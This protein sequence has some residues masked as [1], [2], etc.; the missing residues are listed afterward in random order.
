MATMVARDCMQ[1]GATQNTYPAIT[2]WFAPNTNVNDNYIVTQCKNSYTNFQVNANSRSMARYYYNS[3]GISDANDPANVLGVLVPSGLVVGEYRE[4]DNS[5][6][7]DTYSSAGRTYS[8]RMPWLIAYNNENKRDQTIV[9]Y[10]NGNGGPASFYRNS[11]GSYSVNMPDWG[12]ATNFTWTSIVDKDG[13]T[14]AVYLMFKYNQQ[15]NYNAWMA[16][17]TYDCQLTADG[18]AIKFKNGPEVQMITQF[19]QYLK[20]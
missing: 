16:C 3:Q 2:G 5:V 1:A 10:S 7:T 20:D 9:K 6:K 12:S 17:V 11:T 8:G 4:Y 14:Y 15:V 13:Y 19:D 18:N